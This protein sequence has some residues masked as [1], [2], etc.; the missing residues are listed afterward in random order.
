M[1]ATEQFDAGKELSVGFYALACGLAK[2]L[3][4]TTRRNGIT[5]EELRQAR[6]AVEAMLW[7][8]EAVPGVQ[9]RAVDLNLTEAR[10]RATELL[11][12]ELRNTPREGL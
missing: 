10:W 7:T 3:D 12:I 8:L 11:A 2:I 6:V 1:S 5:D 4:D 9:A